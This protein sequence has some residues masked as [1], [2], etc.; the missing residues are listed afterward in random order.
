MAQR[1]VA[2][3]EQDQDDGEDNEDEARDRYA[4]TAEAEKATE[5]DEAVE[6]LQRAVHASPALAAVTADQVHTKLPP[7]L[8]LSKRQQTL[9]APAER[10]SARRG[11][12]RMRARRR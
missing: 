12:G 6:E 10:V 2:V 8:Q 1:A 4:E 3:A 9:H 11:A 5:A 7:L